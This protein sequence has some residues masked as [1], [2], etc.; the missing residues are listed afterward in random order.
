MKKPEW[1]KGDYWIYETGTIEGEKKTISVRIIGRE[2]I[3]ID[4]DIYYWIVAKGNIIGSEKLTYYEI[5]NLSVVKEI[6]YDNESNESKEIVY[7]P[8]FSLIKY[9]IFIGKKWNTTIKKENNFVNLSFECKRK[10]EISTMAGRFDCYLIKAVYI[11]NETSKPYFYEIIYI[12]SKVGNI[13]KMEGYENN[14]LVGYTELISFHYNADY[15][16]E[17]N[18]FAIAIFVILIFAVVFIFHKFK[19]GN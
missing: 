4:G 14:T 2:N 10:K 8:P 18:Y 9:P 7:N 1:K 15:E 13:V 12:S 19:Y 16:K 6:I 5:E 3:T 17:H 11:F